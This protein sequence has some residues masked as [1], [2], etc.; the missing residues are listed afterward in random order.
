MQYFHC[1]NLL[2]GG[3]QGWQAKQMILVLNHSVE[4][5]CGD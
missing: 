3:L 4:R 2:I 5:I 1:M